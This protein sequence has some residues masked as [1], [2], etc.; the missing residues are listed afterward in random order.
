MQAPRYLKGVSR[1][2][3]D[4]ELESTGSDLYRRW[5]IMFPTSSTQDRQRQVCFAW[6]IRG[7]LYLQRSTSLEHIGGTTVELA[8]FDVNGSEVMMTRQWA[9]ERSNRI[10]QTHGG[11]W[12]NK[13]RYPH[14]DTKAEKCHV[15]ERH[16]ADTT[17]DY[18]SKI[19]FFPRHFWRVPQLF[20][21]S[22]MGIAYACGISSTFG[23][24]QPS[25]ILT[26]PRE[27]KLKSHHN[28]ESNVVRV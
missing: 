5:A 17:Y 19:F 26:S 2:L 25:K 4:N 22:L 21:T 15:Q 27:E 1:S 6:N 10:T 13:M 3:L 23:R 28:D 12:K 14:P 8:V 7:R 11:K 18:G 20:L 16:T 9:D 24:I